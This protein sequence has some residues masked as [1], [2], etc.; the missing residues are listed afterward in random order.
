MFEFAFRFGSEIEI[1]SALQSRASTQSIAGHG[2]KIES[3]ETSLSILI[4]LFSRSNRSSILKDLSHVQPTGVCQ[5]VEEGE[6]Q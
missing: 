4:V 5:A 3:N 1:K 2:G 6:S